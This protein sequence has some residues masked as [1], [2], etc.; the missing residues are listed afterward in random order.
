MGSPKSDSFLGERR[1]DGG[2]ETLSERKGE[3]LESV[4]TR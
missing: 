3:G 2:N 4:P 1:N